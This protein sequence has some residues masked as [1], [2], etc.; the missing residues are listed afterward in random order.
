MRSPANLRY[1]AQDFLFAKSA[2]SYMLAA[3]SHI[4]LG[5]APSAASQ[6]QGQWLCW[7]APPGM[8]VLE[9]QRDQDAA[10][11]DKEV[12]WQGN[13][14]QERHTAV[15]DAPRFSLAHIPTLSYSP[16]WALWNL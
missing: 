2:A 12:P 1:R 15:K 11:Q 13:T 9:Q 16:V 8:G 6:A 14:A 10:L 7:A 3:Q 4:L 5:D